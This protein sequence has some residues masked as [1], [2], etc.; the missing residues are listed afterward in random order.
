LIILEVDEQL[1]PSV[2]T[3]LNE[4]E[5]ETVMPAADIPFDHTTSFI[6]DNNET[7]SPSQNTIVPCAE[8]TGATGSG[9]TVT[10]ITLEVVEQFELFVSITEYEPDSVTEMVLVLAVL[11]LHNKSPVPTTAV[12]FTTPPSQ[13]TSGPSAFT[14]GAIGDVFT[15]TSTDAEG[16]EHPSSKV[17]NTPGVV[18]IIEEL[19]SLVFHKFPTATLLVRVTL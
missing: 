19:V 12:R 16:K 9:F 11:L 1:L 13:K 6:L 18:T 8:I 15:K 2:T 7:D 4:P 10:T 3:A 5:L 14:T 17:V